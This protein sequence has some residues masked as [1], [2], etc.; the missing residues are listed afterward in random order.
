[1]QNIFKNI[2][3]K[4]ILNNLK[5]SFSIV[6]TSLKNNWNNKNIYFDKSSQ[7]PYLLFIAGINR[8]NELNNY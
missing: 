5:L 1:M 6:L 8:L 4:N 2:S 7:N 3:L